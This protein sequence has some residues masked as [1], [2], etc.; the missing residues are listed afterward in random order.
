MLVLVVGPSG[1]GK[2]T[3]IE[4]A[5]RKLEGDR[6]WRFV[7]RVITRAASSGGEAH[8]AVTEA[9]FAQRAF[10][11]QWEAHSLSYGIPADVAQDV[12]HGIVAVANVSRA[13]VADA[14]QRFSVRVVEVTAPPHLRAKR[15]ETRGRE[16][17]EQLASRLRRSVPLPLG[18]W[19][20]TVMNDGSVEEGAAR[21]LAALSR[22]AGIV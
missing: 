18:V 3:L 15:L 8:E 12:A 19:T 21:F 9:E 5:R 11:L 4:A 16:P 17:S 13:V 22:A 6:R 10:A 7:R 1:A 2:D 14:A 20:T